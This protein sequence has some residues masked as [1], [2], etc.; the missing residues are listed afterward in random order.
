M[1]VYRVRYV[2]WGPAGLTKGSRIVALE[3]GGKDRAIAVATHLTMA[4]RFIRDDDFDPAPYFQVLD[5]IEFED[6]EEV[7][8]PDRP[9]G[10]ERQ[11]TYRDA[12]PGMS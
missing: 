2:V 8:L 4:G 7:D 12:A 9:L 11:I 5:C 1:K 3:H 10:P 6:V